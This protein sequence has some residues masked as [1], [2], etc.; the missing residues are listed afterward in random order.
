MENTTDYQNMTEGER[1]EIIA[2]TAGMLQHIQNEINNMYSVL[3]IISVAR[4]GVLLTILAVILLH[5]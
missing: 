5:R 2:Y 3:L 4:M 1:N